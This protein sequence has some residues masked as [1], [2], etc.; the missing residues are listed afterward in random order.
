MRDQ[1]ITFRLEGLVG[2]EDREVL[3][4]VMSISKLQA[5]VQKAA[6]FR[7]EK[8]S[9]TLKHRAFD[10]GPGREPDSPKVVYTNDIYPGQYAGQLGYDPVYIEWDQWSSAASIHKFKSAMTARKPRD[11]SS[12]HRTIPSR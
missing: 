9:A 7:S 8:V 10:N 11:L 3:H 1:V 6:A 4:G 2:T 12:E 5:I